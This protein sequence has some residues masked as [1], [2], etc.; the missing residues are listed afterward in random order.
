MIYY[1]LT[2]QEEER[3]INLYA[4][5]PTFPKSVRHVVDTRTSSPDF[6]FHS[7]YSPHY[8]GKG[9][10]YRYIGNLSLKDMFP[11]KQALRRVKCSLSHEDSQPENYIIIVFTQCVPGSVSLRVC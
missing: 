7:L 8:Q 6:I 5:N 9:M 10:L 1:V 3:Y 11:T 2:V 4:S